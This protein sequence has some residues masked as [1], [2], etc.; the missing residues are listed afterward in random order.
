MAALVTEAVAMACFGFAGS[1]SILFIAR[2][3]QGLATGAA[4]GAV[5]AALVDLQ[6][7]G[8]PQLASLVNSA[9]PTGLAGVRGRHARAHRRLGARRPLPGTRTVHRRGAPSLG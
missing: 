2:I 1:V 5:S 3:M 4:M 6:P 9:A 8:S 7:D